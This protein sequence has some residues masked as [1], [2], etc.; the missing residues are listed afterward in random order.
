MEVTNNNQNTDR[1]RKSTSEN[2]NKKIDLAIKDNVL[3]Y[4]NKSKAEI[5]KRIIAL[6]L[7]WSIERKI[8]VNASSLALT[9][10]LLGAFV[11]IYWL[12]LPAVV[13][14]FLLQHGLQ[15]WCPPVP[16]FRALNTRTRKE[17]DWEKFTLKVIRGDFDIISKSNPAEVLE[18]VKNN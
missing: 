8:E 9:G 10:V 18:A 5:S 11:H 6:E 15:G 7:E 1:V 14:G 13:M 2:Q 17:I 4:K 12:I 3:K 16:I